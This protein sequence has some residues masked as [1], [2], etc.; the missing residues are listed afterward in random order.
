M[1]VELVRSRKAKPSSMDTCQASKGDFLLL[2][3]ILEE[4]IKV[5]EAPGRKPKASNTEESIQDLRIPFNPLPSGRVD[6]VT[7]RN[8]HRW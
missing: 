7:S 4:V 8:A 2:K 5:T 6:V 3:S 1:R